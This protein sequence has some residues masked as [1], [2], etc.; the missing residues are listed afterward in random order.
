[1]RASRLLAS[2]CGLAVLLASCARDNAADLAPAPQ[3]PTDDVQLTA[4]AVRL[5]GLETTT[6][7]SEIVAR[8][9]TLSGVLAGS[10]WTPAER[11]VTSAVDS[12]DARL[13]LAESQSAR[14]ENLVAQGIVAQQE[15][16]VARS[17]LDQARAAAAELDAERVNLGLTR[18]P[19]VLDPGQIWGLATLPES[20]LGAVRS[21]DRVEVRTDAS[22]GSSFAGRVVDISGAADAQTRSFTL[23]VAIDDP[24][25]ALRSQMLARFAIA[26]S[27]RTGLALPSSAVLLEG[28]GAWVYVARSATRFHRQPVRVEPVAPDRVLVLG[29]L[30]AGDA[31]VT[32]GAQLL[33]AERLKRSFT[34]IETD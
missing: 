14:Q 26:L 5:A 18:K 32:R 25:H 27:P 12:A 4:E 15:G 16:D 29:G 3:P 11:D 19:L 21:G 28:S 6:V 2:L 17:E 22:P 20:Q 34:P 33:E 9:L 23:R 7:R 13:H 8:S 31:V 10:P 30:A 24:G 1:M